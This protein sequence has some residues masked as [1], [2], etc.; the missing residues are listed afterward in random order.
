MDQKQKDCIIKITDKYGDCLSDKMVGNSCNKRDNRPQGFVEIYD[1]SID[2]KKELLGKQNLVVYNGRE[3]LISRAFK[4]KNTMITA[5]ENDFITWFGVGDGG[6]PIGD[7]LNPTSPDSTDSDLSNSV[8]INATDA[9]CADYR[10]VPDVGYYKHPFD[11]DLEFEQD[12][13]NYNYWLIGKVE[14]TISSADANG[15]NLNE[16]GLFAAAS[17]AGG[18]GGPFTLYARVTF[19]T[20][21]KTS[22]RQLLFVWYVYF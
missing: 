1:I 22:S 16:A 13:D 14:T 20:I 9:T 10:L 2:N 5:G 21:S 7:P 4:V 12:G 8:M 19:P 15:F 18:Y 6:C 11:S 3:W 17:D